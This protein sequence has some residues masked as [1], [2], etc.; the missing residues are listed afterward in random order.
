MKSVFIAGSRAVSRLNAQVKERLDSIMKQNLT[1]LIGDANGAD[2]AVQGYLAKCNYQNVV[3]YTMQ[4]CR[5]NIG[6]WPTR[7]HTA[8]M[9][10]KR[11]RHYRDRHYYG[12]KDLAMATDADC[13]F[14]LWD[15]TSKGTLTNIVNLLNA[16][17]KALLYLAP[18][19][20]FFKLHTFKD[21]QEALCANGIEDVPELLA[22][23]GLRDA[24]P[25]GATS[26]R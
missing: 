18:K 20:S 19:K 17:K 23:M 5:N 11:D 14:M 6:D 7:S 1:V 25:Q 26:V 10:A 21:L 24:I 15:G 16:N 9:G 8:A 2:N 22:A 13:G 12:I 4:P 3:V